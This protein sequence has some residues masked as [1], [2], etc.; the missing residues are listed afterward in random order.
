MDIV[1][2]NATSRRDG[3]PICQD[4]HRE[5]LKTLYHTCVPDAA[6]PAGFDRL[7]HRAAHGPSPYTARYER[8]EELRVALGE[9]A[10]A[11]AARA[12][13]PGCLRH[14]VTREDSS[15]LVQDPSPMMRGDSLD[16]RCR[17]CTRGRASCRHIF[18]GVSL[19][20]GA[21][22]GNDGNRTSSWHRATEFRHDVCCVDRPAERRVPLPA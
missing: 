4:E 17:I 3:V 18:A 20:R 11:A 9:A 12:D 5:M 2:T 10:G 21:S 13:R 1:D 16:L 15:R 6:R 8:R 19:S 22:S 7:A 14:E